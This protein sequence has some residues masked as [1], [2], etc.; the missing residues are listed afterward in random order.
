M[1][2]SWTWLEIRL[3]TRILEEKTCELLIRLLSSTSGYSPVSKDKCLCVS[4]GQ[5]AVLSCFKFD[6]SVCPGRSAKHIPTRMNA[7]S[8][9]GK[10]CMTKWQ[11]AFELF[12]CWSFALN[13]TATLF[14]VSH[15]CFGFGYHLFKY[16]ELIVRNDFS[17]FTFSY[18]QWIPNQ[19]WEE[20]KERRILFPKESGR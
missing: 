3:L 19:L 2:Y 18:L 14:S 4:M 9:V 13:L 17:L 20:K 1:R 10:Q 5:F 15:L 12:T 6:L 11:V 8:C 7:D 16:W